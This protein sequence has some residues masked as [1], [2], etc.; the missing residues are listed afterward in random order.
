MKAAAD[1]PR[2]CSP[3]RRWD[4]M[5]VLDNEY[6]HRY[7]DLTDSQRQLVKRYAPLVSGGEPP[8]WPGNKRFG[9]LPRKSR[10]SS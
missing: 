3:G 9:T 1:I 10:Q 4:L 2:E 8:W 6:E 5:Q 7:R